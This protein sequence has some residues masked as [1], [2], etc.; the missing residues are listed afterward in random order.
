[1]TT[2]MKEQPKKE[3]EITWD[4]IFVQDQA[5]SEFRNF[6]RNCEIVKESIPYHLLAGNIWTNDL[7]KNNDTWL[8][9]KIQQ[10]KL[11]CD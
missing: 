4:V 10:N 5:G 8:C 9:N 6:I 3:I 1:M 11:R 7:Y 2:S